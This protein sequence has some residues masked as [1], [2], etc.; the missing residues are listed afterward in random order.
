MFK[1]RRIVAL[2]IFILTLTLGFWGSSRYPALSSKAALS[3]ASGFEDPMTHEAHFKVPKNAPLHER[4]FYTTLNWYETNW[5]GMTFGLALAAAFLAL[6]TYLPKKPS[7]NRFVNSFRGLLAGTPL[8]VCVNCVAPIAKGIYEAGSKMETALAVMFSSPTL[9]I[10]VLT[11]VFSIFPL[12][13]A[14]LKL[15]GTLA[16]VLLILPLISDK[17]RKPDREPVPLA[18]E[19]ACSWD[20][21]L[22]SWPQA[23]GETARDYWKSFKYIF[24]RTFPLMLFAG[25]LGALAS[26]VWNFD[27]MIGVE[28][29]LS[30][31][32]LISFMGTFLPLPIAFDVMLAQALMTSGFPDGFV[33]T[34]LFTLGTFSVY[35]AMIVWRTFSF[36]IAVQ[37]YIIVCVLGIGLGYAANAWSERQFVQ[38]LAGYEEILTDKTGKSGAPSKARRRQAL[39]EQADTLAPTIEQIET[40]FLNTE[41]LT[42]DYIPHQKRTATGVAA[43]RKVTGP[44]LGIEYANEIT[45][46]TFFDPLYFGRGV[47][48]GD[49]NKDGWIDLAVATDN[50]FELYQ[51]VNGDRFQ[52]WAI[53]NRQLIGKQGISVAF[54]DM[55]NDGWLDVFFTAFNDGNYIWLNPGTS[56]KFSELISVPRN[57]SMLTSALGFS[58]LNRDGFLDV[59]NGNYYLGILTRTPNNASFNQIIFNDK[60]NFRAVDLAGIPGQTHST[61]FSDV[62]GD[63]LTDLLV[64][65]DYRVADEYYFGKGEGTFDKVK[66]SDGV[67]PLTTENTMSV[68]SADFDNDLVPDFYLAN[69]GF[70]RGLDV[71]S[72]IFGD[73]MQDAGKAFCD[74]GKSVLDSPAC[75]E[76]L[77]L[78][79]LLNP[80]KQD[81]TEK[82]SLLIGPKAI[83][84][85]MVSR[86]AL[87]AVKRNDPDLCEK[88]SNQYPLLQTVCNGFF[89]AEKVTAN[90]DREIP[91]QSLFN[92]LMRGKGDGTFEDVSEPTG[93]KT[94]EWSWNARFADLDNDEW[95]DLFVVNGVLITQE[96]ASNNFF[97]NREGKTFLDEAKA[98]GLDD[99]DH[100]SSYTYLDMDADG[101]LDI[102]ANT[103]YG[104]FKVYINN[105]T[106]NNSVGFRLWDGKGNR[107]CVGCKIIIHYG[108]AGEQRQFREIK[109]SGGFHS[110]DAPRA[111]F[112]LGGFE[113]VESVE[114]IWSD[115]ERSPINETF[116]ANREYIIKRGKN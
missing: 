75:H 114:I 21:G 80:E 18:N 102:V 82:C 20:G 13:M 9:N 110:F 86:M 116:P 41:T 12:Y 50:G 63:S 94:A 112:G 71:V 81:V 46:A 108:P 55:N 6:L 11:M 40:P 64:G 52:R 49:F 31:L 88:I 97:H 5:R 104:P 30:N 78:A 79:T 22:E 87:T 25:F 100:S 37:L 89:K 113:R 54:A 42:I 74:S 33:V 99:F 56:G 7:P 111:H 16:L 66:R 27:H 92:I 53:A 59:M 62:N 39:I 24:V 105:E 70:T 8:G 106:K 51:N 85:C 32:G 45:P 95:Q 15:G 84:E 23:F 58:D 83:R 65:N 10:I 34:L 29:N 61:L 43:F 107:F 96:F 14:L 36:K 72:N 69:I 1:N 101:D 103:L 67:V 19:L 73:A 115:G 68:D 98:F 91:I 47:A 26:H 76:L 77:K 109:T 35:S 60:L 93:V 48:S 38:W 90:G 2:L 57:N 28:I 4:V 44:E 3:G 17:E